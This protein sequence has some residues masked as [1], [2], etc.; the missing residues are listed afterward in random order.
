MGI[1]STLEQYK[2]QFDANREG[3]LNYLPYSMGANLT[4][5]Q[6][7][8]QSVFKDVDLEEKGHYRKERVEKMHALTNQVEKLIDE[9]EERQKYSL[10]A[11][12]R[13]V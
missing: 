9:F 12:E 13:K 3:R 1:E 2:N 11:L 8:C 7:L 5:L 10:V 6:G 4:Q